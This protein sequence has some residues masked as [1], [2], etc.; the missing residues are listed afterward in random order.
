GLDS[1]RVRSR[2]GGEREH[3]GRPHEGRRY[4]ERSK[5]PQRAPENPPKHAGIMR[6]P[7]CSRRV[8]SRPP[9][10]ASPPLSFVGAL[11][12]DS[13]TGQRS[14]PRIRWGK[15]RGERSDLARDLGDH[16][17]RELRRSALTRGT[18]GAFAE[19]RTA[20]KWPRRVDETS[21]V[22]AE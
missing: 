14:R 7:R 8:E 11:P 6:D 22:V 21:P 18:S 4:D 2:I 12:D 10:L 15:A 20:A 3:V 19:E 16:L 1:A 9:A 5:R 17:L 13:C